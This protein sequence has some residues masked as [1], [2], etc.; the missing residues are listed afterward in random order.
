MVFDCL[1]YTQTHFRNG[2]SA[3]FTS[4][5]K[6]IKIKFRI[7]TIC[8]IIVVSIARFGIVLRVVFMYRYE[9]KDTRYK[10]I[11]FSEMERNVKIGCCRFQFGT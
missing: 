8:R 10:T 3:N 2:T 1:T 9:L 6:F 11:F 5:S 4:M 7:N